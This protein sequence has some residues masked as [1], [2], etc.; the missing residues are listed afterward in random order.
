VKIQDAANS[1]GANPGVKVMSLVAGMV[2]GADSIEDIDRLRHA[3]NALVF[4]GVRAP[5]TLVTFLRAFTHGHSVHRRR[6]GCERDRDGPG[7]ADLVVWLDQLNR[8]DHVVEVGEG[9]DLPDS[10]VGLCE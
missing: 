8:L 4:S 7:T 1:A 5:S 6:T 10:Q 9:K 3:G 2:V